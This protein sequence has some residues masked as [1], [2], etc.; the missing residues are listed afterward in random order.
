MNEAQKCLWETLRE[1]LDSNLSKRTGPISPGQYGPL[2]G[3]GLGELFVL[4][5]YVQSVAD[6]LK[7]R[8]WLFKRNNLGQN[9]P[10]VPSSYTEFRRLAQGRELSYLSFLNDLDW[11]STPSRI[12]ASAKSARRLTDFLVEWT[13]TAKV[14]EFQLFVQSAA[15]RMTEVVLFERQFSTLRGLGE[16]DSLDRKL[17]PS[18]LYRAFDPLDEVFGFAYEENFQVSEAAKQERLY[19][20]S[21]V[22][23]QTSYATIVEVLEGLNLTKDSLV[24][25]LGS[26]FGRMGL[27]CGLWRSD[28]R[29]LGYEFVPSRVV[30]SNAAAVKSGIS[31]RVVFHAQDLSDSRFRIPTAQVYYMYDPFSQVTYRRILKDLIEIG[32]SREIVVVTKGDAGAW[33]TEAVTG[34]GWSSPQILDNGNMLSVN[35]PGLS[36]PSKAKSLKIS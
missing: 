10:E 6:V 16:N 21:G 3:S 23:V 22:G 5:M 24:V 19:L 30:M 28:I 18:S 8:V 20:G 1:S 25:D 2:N 36:G 26:G 11:N 29:F 31:S 17:L 34:E 33:L 32:R 35:S 12:E 15:R 27:F 9:A 13:K 14:G 7:D 4:S